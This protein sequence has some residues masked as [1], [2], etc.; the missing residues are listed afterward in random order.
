MRYYSLCGLHV[1]WRMRWAIAPTRYGVFR[2]QN[3]IFSAWF[4]SDRL[5]IATRH[6]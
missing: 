2:I 6:K 1:F 5:V 4:V 3:E